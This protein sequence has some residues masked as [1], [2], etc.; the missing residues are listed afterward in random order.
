MAEPSYARGWG[1]RATRL[2]ALA[3]LLGVII[4]LLVA[5]IR[6]VAYGQ[7]WARVPRGTVLVG[8][9]PVVGLLLSGVVMYRWADRSSSHDTEAYI[10]AYHSGEV[11]GPRSAAAKTVAALATVGLGGAAGLEGPAMYLGSVVGGWLRPA[12]RRLGVSDRRATRSLMVAGAAAGISAVFSAP[13]T[14]LIFAL[15]APYA[16]DFARE[17]LVPALVSSVS[18]YLVLVSILG[19]EPLFPVSRGLSPSLRVVL[20]ALVLGLLLGLAARAMSTASAWLR[21]VFERTRAPLP[22]RTLIGGLACGAFGVAALWLV[23]E[24]IALGSGYDLVN[25]TMAG[26]YIGA[27][28]L[29]VLALRAGAVLAT[30]SSGAAGGTF[31]PFMSL[32]AVAGG[33]FEGILPGSGALFPVIGMAAFL[34]AANATPVAAAVFVAESTGSAGYIIP[35]LVAATAAYLVGGRRSITRSQR[36]NRRRG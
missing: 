35:G 14:G 31:I 9:F 7:L 30:L 29:L 19:P 1:Q 33:V 13:L 20:L 28:A 25:A 23:G 4:G 12:L 18:S 15:E 32:G 16:D 21:R 27:T 3:L 5:G 36:P 22:L 34:A 10:E 24:P 6:A 2:A 26:R 11:D 8:L 17:A